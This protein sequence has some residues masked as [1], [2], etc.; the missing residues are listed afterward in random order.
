MAE[1]ILAW[2]CII[3]GAGCAAVAMFAAW[4]TALERAATGSS[5]NDRTAVWFALV[6]F[7]GIGGGI[8]ILV[9]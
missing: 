9:F 2:L 6:A 7:A 3:V 4:A 1:I 5:D 8:L